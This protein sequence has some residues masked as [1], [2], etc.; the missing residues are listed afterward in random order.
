MLSIY[1]RNRSNIRR[2]RDVKRRWHSILFHSFCAVVSKIQIL[3]ISR[4]AQSIVSSASNIKSS[5]LCCYVNSVWR[6]PKF[7]RDWTTLHN[8]Y[9]IILCN[10]ERCEIVCCSIRKSAHIV[11]TW[12]IL[13]LNKFFN[14][15]SSICDWSWVSSSFVSHNCLFSIASKQISSFHIHNF[16]CIIIRQSQ[17]FDDSLRCIYQQFIFSRDTTSISTF[18]CIFDIIK[19]LVIKWVWCCE[20][21]SN[22][23]IWWIKLLQCLNQTSI[24]SDCIYTSSV[25]HCF[26]IL[27][28]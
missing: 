8:N 7:W 20:L 13:I 6:T 27:W 16:I 23:Y 22:S 2:S 3:S 5:E 17:I 15:K 1:S 19:T 25:R 21:H 4:N 18:V 11:S 12:L 26:F 24:K 10:C 14:S 9:C 28:E